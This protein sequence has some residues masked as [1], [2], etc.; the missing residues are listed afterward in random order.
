MKRSRSVVLTS[1]LA[2]GGLVLSGCDAPQQAQAPWLASNGPAQSQPATGG[3]GLGAEGA[4]AYADL[5]EC[6]AANEVPDEQCQASYEQALNQAPRFNDQPSC[7]EQYGQGQCVPR[8]QAGGGSFFVPLLTGF[9]VARALG[10]F[11]GGYYGYR[12]PYRDRYYRGGAYGGYGRGYGQRD[13]VTGR[14]YDRGYTGAERSRSPVTSR[15][16]F[17]GG[18]RGYG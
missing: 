14:S 15:G 18:G 10:G 11:G 13:Y 17:G 8:T 12:S 7:E 4:R 16:G 3:Q 9:L 1:F 6:R 5:A 2:S